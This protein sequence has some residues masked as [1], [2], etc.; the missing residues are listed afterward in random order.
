MNRQKRAIV[1]IFVVLM[2]SAMATILL[3]SVDMGRMA[4]FKQKQQERDTKWQYCLDSAKAYVIQS[5]LDTAS[6]TQSL[7]LTVNGVD[8]SISCAADSSFGGANGCKITVTGTI[9]GKPRTSTLSIG[10]LMT[11]NPCTFAAY[12]V[13]KFQPT[14]TAAL[15]GDLYYGGTFDGSQLSLT[16]N[17]YSTAA[18]APTI[19][20]FPGTFYG[21]QP[22][23][24]IA[25]NDTAYA[26]AASIITSGST[27]LSNPVNLLSLSQSQ[28]RYHTG[29]L[30][31]TG[32]VTGEMTIFVQ[33]SVVI[34][35]V[36]P[37][38]NILSRLV[39]ICDG[40]IQFAPGTSGVFAVASGK[41]QLST[42][43]G[44][45]TVNGSIAGTEFSNTGD[46]FSVNFDNYFLTTRSGGFRYWLPGQW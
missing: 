6:T 23:P 40:D 13:T 33:G 28:L 11:V 39:I 35:N 22:T 14:G 25:L 27:T 36:T 7:S 19:A 45:C 10:K 42:S 20:S 31:I 1:M 16:G 30:T 17:V 26:A 41:I 15:A 12:F 18:S 21:R 24:K 32:T 46:A 4:V 3:A 34:D 37:L 43:T 8:L 9:D 38:T 5:L 44:T 2:M 29:N